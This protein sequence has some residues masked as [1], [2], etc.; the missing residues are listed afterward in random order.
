MPNWCN[1]TLTIKHEDAA[2]L[3]RVRDAIPTE[4]LFG[5]FFPTPPELLETV[6]IGE[7]FMDRS[8]KREQENLEKFGYADWYNWNIE[9]WG[10]KWD[11][12]ELTLNVNWTD[13]LSISFD[14]AWGPP[15]VFYQKMTELGFE[16]DY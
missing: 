3:Q 12:N 9:N 16:I 6:P 7:D 8:K 1:N 2:M 5:A 11:T 13:T 15:V 4:N 14:T 10:T